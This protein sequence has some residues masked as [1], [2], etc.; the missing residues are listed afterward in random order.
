MNPAVDSRYVSVRISSLQT[1]KHEER[2]L[3]EIQD[4]TY[5]EDQ[6]NMIEDRIKKLRDELNKRNEEI[7]ILKG[8]ASKQINQIRGSI[9]KFLGKETGTLGETIRTLFKGTG[10]NDSI[11]IDCY[12]YG[13]RSSDRS[14]TR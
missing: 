14:S 7:N 5:S 11:H 8:K 4:P 3:N 10:Y 9:T 1:Y 13:H 2:K 6:R 12:W